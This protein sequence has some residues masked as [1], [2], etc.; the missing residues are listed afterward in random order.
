MDIYPPYLYQE[1]LA[2]FMIEGHFGRHIRK[3]RQTYSERRAVL[4]QS[5]SEQCGDLW[6]C[7][8]AKRE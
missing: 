4:I 2:D 6:R 7:R 3:M 1:V 5:L 8:G